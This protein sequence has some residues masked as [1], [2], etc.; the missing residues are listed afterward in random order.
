MYNEYLTH[1]NDFKRQEAFLS[2]LNSQRGDE[3]YM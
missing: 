1:Y 3:K 2:Y